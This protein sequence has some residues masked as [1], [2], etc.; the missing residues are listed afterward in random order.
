[1]NL[2]TLISIIKPFLPLGSTNA[3]EA[4]ERWLTPPKSSRESLYKGLTD[5]EKKHADELLRT[6]TDA[7]S[8]YTVYV[9]SRGSIDAD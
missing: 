8:D 7:V 9:A 6:A 4:V 5:E 3:H 2:Q 1:M